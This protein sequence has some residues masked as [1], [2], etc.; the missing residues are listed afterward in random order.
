MSTKS[1]HHR[2]L[3]RSVATICKEKGFDTVTKASLE[4]LTEMLQCH[5]AE[6][7]HS[8]RKFCEHSHRTTPDLTDCAMAL[9][10]IGLSCHAV[11]A[12][13]K[14]TVTQQAPQ[15]SHNKPTP[16]H[17]CFKSA[18]PKVSQPS[19]VPG[20]LVEYPEVYSFVRTPS[21]R[22]PISQY[23]TIRERVSK[24][25]IMTE[26]SLIK[27]LAHTQESEVTL[28]D[29]MHA[30][31]YPTIRIEHKPY[32]YLEAL[33]PNEKE[34]EN[35]VETTSEHDVDVKSEDTSS[36]DITTTVSGSQ[37]SLTSSGSISTSENLYVSKPKRMRTKK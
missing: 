15:L 7:T 22:E 30:D 21:V 29:D 37:S 35:G 33:L 12:Y 34:K 5:L 19:Y 24:Q 13:C 20:H 8:C 25:N 36:D 9:A 17:K 31:L 1:T 23:E 26:E 32:P 2:L 14:T 3:Q 4:T 28:F 6:L 18:L 16:E 27:F 10:E 11:N